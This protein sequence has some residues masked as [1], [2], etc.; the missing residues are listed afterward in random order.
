MKVLLIAALTIFSI[1]ALAQSNNCPP[2]VSSKCF[3]E[4]SSRRGHTSRM[5]AR[6]C[7]DVSNDCYIEARNE[8][9][10][11]KRSKR[12]C[13]NVS[14]NCF[15]DVFHKHSPDMTSD[16]VYHHK[17]IEVSKVCRNVNNKCYSESRNIG[18]SIHRSIKKCHDVSTNCGICDLLSSN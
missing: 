10:S 13:F 5:A 8:G 12:I 1:S 7:R 15:A 2:D 11:I 9:V 16:K 6:F 17:V 18:R 3:K 4:L 14:N